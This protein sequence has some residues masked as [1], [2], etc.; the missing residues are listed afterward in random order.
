VH[1]SVSDRDNAKLGMYEH[2]SRSYE[3]RVY[4][5]TTAVMLR[6]PTGAAATAWRTI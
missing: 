5:A 4:W 6:R 1:R 2:L 3:S